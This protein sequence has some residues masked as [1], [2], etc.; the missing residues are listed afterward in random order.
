MNVKRVESHIVASTIPNFRYRCNNYRCCQRKFTRKEKFKRNPFTI[1]SRT[2]TR[3]TIVQ[4]TET[5]VELYWKEL[6]WQHDLNT[7]TTYRL[8]EHTVS[9]PV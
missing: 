3:V 8:I 6:F 1:I 5:N 4:T 7:F 2:T 9:I